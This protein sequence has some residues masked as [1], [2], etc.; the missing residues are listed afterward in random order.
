MK[1]VNMCEGPLAKK[2]LRFTVPVM[3]TGLLQLLYSTA[4]VVILG[5]LGGEASVSAVGA[6]AT[7][8]NLIVNVF[9]GLSVG[10]TVTAA[11]AIGARNADTVRD[12]VQTTAVLGVLCGAVAG[13][14][15]ILFSPLLLTAMHTPTETM[16][17]A[18]LYPAVFSRCA[19]KPV[20]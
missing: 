7:I 20:V 10:V 12:T 9:M 18:V 17:P 11:A 13:T 16:H 2:L 1:P 3:L 15:G 14:L 4:D 6:T 8:I 5:N 19:R